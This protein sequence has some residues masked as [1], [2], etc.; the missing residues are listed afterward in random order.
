VTS[1]QPPTDEPAATSP[2]AAVVAALVDPLLD[3]RIQPAADEF[4]RLIADA[5]TAGAID[6]ELARQLRFWQRAS[7]HELADHVRTVLPAVL[8][9][10]MAAVTAAATEAQASAVAAETAW[11]D[12][13]TP[14]PVP[15]EDL[16]VDPL[17]GVV[18]SAP[19][20][21]VLNTAPAGD[22]T[23]ADPSTSN[24]HLRR[25]LFV[26]GLTALPE[27]SHDRAATAT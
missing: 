10:A 26:A 9:V 14:I 22:D 15:A 3:A 21:I 25:R 27:E 12:K 16:A 18:L 6:Q 8:P 1:P 20:E 13:D 4:D 23:E 19:D 5:L 11:R 2:G 24:A 17:Q 7:V